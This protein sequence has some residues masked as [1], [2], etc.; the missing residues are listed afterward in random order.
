MRIKWDK[1]IRK[2]GINVVVKVVSQYWK[3][4]GNFI[5]FSFVVKKH[6]IYL[7]L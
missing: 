6:S 7:N 3:K 1:F 4:L 5:C 2:G